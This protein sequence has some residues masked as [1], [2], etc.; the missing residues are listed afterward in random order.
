MEGSE[1]VNIWLLVGYVLFSLLGIILVVEKVVQ[2][3]LKKR[4]PGSPEEEA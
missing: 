1:A 4:R 2:E 3:R